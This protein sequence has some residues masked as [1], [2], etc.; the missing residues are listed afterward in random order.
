MSLY[1]ILLQE[2][3]LWP[4][5]L[6]KLSSIIDG[7]CAIGVSDSTLHE[8]SDLHRGC[9]AVAFLWR[10]SL[11]ITRVTLN[12]R[13]NRLCATELPLT[14]GSIEWAII[15]NIICPLL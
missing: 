12:V 8:T 14:S 3:W 11:P 1:I 13:S 2:H 4:F 6:H 5:E 15:F 9:C 7:F 10:K